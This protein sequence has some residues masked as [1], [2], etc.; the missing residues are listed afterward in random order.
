[1][2]TKKKRR[3]IS[4]IF[5]IIAIIF[6]AL[7]NIGL[8]IYTIDLVHEEIIWGDRLSVPNMC[9]WDLADGDYQRMYETLWLY[10]ETDEETHR[11]WRIAYAYEDMID[12]LTYRQAV[13]IGLLSPQGEDY[14]KFA[15]EA[16]ACI[17]ATGNVAELEQDKLIIEYFAAEATKDFPVWPQN[18]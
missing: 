3:P 8:V 2:A 7:I 11:F 6:F 18:K 17:K 10:R 14:A 15:E 16:L 9:E 1:M 12:C 5:K 4:F 13:A